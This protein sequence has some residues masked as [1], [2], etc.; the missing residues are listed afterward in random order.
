MA[1]NRLVAISPY[2]PLP[3]LAL[4]VHALTMHGRHQESL[5]EADRS[6]FVAGLLGDV[7]TQRVV[8]LGRVYALAALGRLDEALAVGERLA[9]EQGGPLATNAKIFADVAET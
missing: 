6:E 7:R 3:G 9:A 2:G 5:V 1:D 8:R 4:D